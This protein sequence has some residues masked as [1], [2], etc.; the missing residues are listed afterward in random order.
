MVK[1]EDPEG[2]METGICLFLTGKMGF[3]TLEL[4]LELGFISHKTI[5]NGNGL[6]F[7]Q[8]SHR[9]GFTLFDTRI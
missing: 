5:E 4:E 7:E 8:G 6:K 1:I 9:M 2:K 3:H